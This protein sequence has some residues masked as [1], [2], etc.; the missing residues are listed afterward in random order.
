MTEDGTPRERDRRLVPDEVAR[1]CAA[2]HPSRDVE[3]LR[4]VDPAVPRPRSRKDPFWSRWDPITSRSST[5][6]SWRGGMTPATTH[7]VHRTLRRALGQAER[8]KLV[9][10]NA[11]AVVTPPRPEQREMHT[12]TAEQVR[13]LLDA[14]PDR[15]CPLYLLAVSSGMRLGELLALRWA[16]VDLDGGSLRVV[17]HP[18]APLGRG[19]DL[20]AA[21]DGPVATS[22][23]AFRVGRR[24]AERPQGRDHRGAVAS[25]STLAGPGPRP[26][27]SESPWPATRILERQPRVPPAA[28][29]RRSA[30]NPLSR[31]P[32]HGSDPHAWSRRLTPSSSRTCSVTRASGS[33]STRTRMRSRRCTARPRRSWRSY[34]AE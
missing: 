15:Y 7:Y 12:L 1:W 2:D 33:P 9:T 13:R 17:C 29:T 23:R 27:L 25:R 22:R 14:A 26:R 30:A 20:R 19:S 32:P 10:S 6:T 5:A 18:A 21:Q 3:T 34:S 24:R 28:R 11:A 8:W 31:P 4:A 16:D